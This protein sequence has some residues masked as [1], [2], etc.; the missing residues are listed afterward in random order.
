[1]VVFFLFFTGVIL[2]TCFA[3]ASSTGGANGPKRVVIIRISPRDIVVGRALPDVPNILFNLC[4]CL[5]QYYKWNL[6]SL[7]FQNILFV[8][9]N[10]VYFFQT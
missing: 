5:M 3:K 1:M 6:I 9:E 7:Q 8:S 4:K 2:S 10:S